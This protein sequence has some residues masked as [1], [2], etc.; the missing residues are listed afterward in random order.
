V[1]HELVP[2]PLRWVCSR[3]ILVSLCL[4]WAAAA[5]GDA[6]WAT[7]RWPNQRTDAPA[8]PVF[9]AHALGLRLAATAIAYEPEAIVVS[10]RLTNHGR[11]S[12]AIERA[13]IMLALDEL[14]YAPIQAD[15]N[16][17][18]PAWL[19]LEPSVDAE[20]RL[21]YDLGRPLVSSES[22][23]IVRSLTCDDVAVIELPELP[24]PAM[25]TSG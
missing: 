13:A 24:L 7:V 9:E 12:L 14:E 18:A 10:L 5:C 8:Q 2:V 4:A 21:R 17:L 25:P 1:Y 16:D 23:L 22:R 6:H 3:V 15:P 19:I 11:A 20:L